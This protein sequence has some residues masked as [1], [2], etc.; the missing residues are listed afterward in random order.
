V[1]EA[2]ENAHDN[3]SVFW[4]TRVVEQEV[5]HATS[6][7]PL[8]DEAAVGS[9]KPVV[10]DDTGG[11]HVMSAVADGPKKTIDSSASVVSVQRRYIVSSKN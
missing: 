8:L 11:C 1:L 4:L 3:A 10:G 6:G 7:C 9:M 5:L 2:C